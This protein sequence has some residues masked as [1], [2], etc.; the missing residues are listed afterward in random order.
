MKSTSAAL[1]IIHALWPGPATPTDGVVSPAGIV[2]L[3]SLSF[4][5]TLSEAVGSPLVR[6]ASRPAMRCS[7]VGGGGGGAAGAAVSAANAGMAAM[8][9][10]SK[11]TAAS[12]LGTE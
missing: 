10:A 2:G 3:P 12:V 4:G 9:V 6:Y 8:T 1:V 11:A 5:P 7:N